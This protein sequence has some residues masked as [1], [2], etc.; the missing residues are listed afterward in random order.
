MSTAE[1]PPAPSV[2]DPLPAPVTPSFAV[3]GPPLVATPS[4][5]SRV[6]SRSATAS[7]GKRKKGNSGAAAAAAPDVDVATHEGE[8][9]YA[10]LAAAGLT[11]ALEHIR[12]QDVII[13]DLRAA[14]ARADATVV[15]ERADRRAVLSGLDLVS[16]S[17]RD[18][19][20]AVQAPIAPA[21][22]NTEFPPLRPSV[23]TQDRV[24]T[25]AT[26]D[27]HPPR[28]SQPTLATIAARSARAQPPAATPAPGLRRPTPATMAL[29]AAVQ[30]P[31]QAPAETL[32]A[33]VRSPAAIA[34][35]Q[36]QKDDYA[37]IHIRNLR[38]MA[39]AAVREVCAS[40]GVNIAHVHDVSRVGP[41]T[42]L[43]V[44]KERRDE[45]VS[46]LSVIPD[47]SAPELAL[48]LDLDFDASKPIATDANAEMAERVRADFNAR[49]RE[50]QNRC[51]SFGWNGLADFFAGRV[52]TAATRRA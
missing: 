20:A 40:L 42:E 22:A 30:R 19:K 3:G 17:L 27:F 14:L 1:T 45:I 18:V 15:S 2:G 52:S 24:P 26:F 28:T 7:S 13:A 37:L 44:T 9:K 31:R 6:A 35:S 25:S 23:A 29:A 21:Q 32:R 38:R 11:A 8:E 34:R 50:Q 46:Q 5:A 4:P 51:S 43:V 10:R 16:A 12:G 36:L 49:M 33:A 48:Q 47:S 41:V 39:P